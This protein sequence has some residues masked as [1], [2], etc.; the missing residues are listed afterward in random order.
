[1]PRWSSPTGSAW[2]P[3]TTTTPALDRRQAGLHER[4]RLPDAVRRPRRHAD[5]RLPG[6]H[7]H[8]RRGRRRP[9]PPRSKRCSTT[10]SARWA[11]TARSE[12]TCTPTTLTLTPVAEAV[13]AAAQARGV[14]VISVQAAARL[15][16]RSQRL[17]DSAASAG[18]T[19]LALRAD[20]WTGAPGAPDDAALAG[21][22]E[23]ADRDHPR[24]AAQ[25]LHG[26]DDQ[27]HPVRDLRRR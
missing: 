15:D 14:P 21:P 13:V 25:S 10:R 27:G 12:S 9:T 11:T 22:S 1:M 17:D 3:T 19:T 23:D 5:R 20:T 4:R 16:R 2:T 7:E 24:R 6:E 8:E 18:T 26:E